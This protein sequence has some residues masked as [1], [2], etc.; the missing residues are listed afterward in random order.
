FYD[1]YKKAA[2]LT[3][4]DTKA[5][6]EVGRFLFT[7]WPELSEE[8]KLYTLGLL[9]NLRTNREN[10]QT[11]MQIWAINGGD[12]SVMEDILPEE[13]GVYR[14]FAQF[15]ANRKLSI[16]ERHKKLAQAE[17]M[18]FNSAKNSFVKGEREAQSRNVNQAISLF[19][20]SL[21]AIENLQFY[22]NLTGETLIDLLEVHEYKKSLY[23]N[24]IKYLVIQSGD[25]K[26]AEI[27]LR[28]YLD[29]ENNLTE[30]GDLD[31]FLKERN[32]LKA[33]PGTYFNDLLPYYIR[34]LIEYKLNRNRDIVEGGKNL[35]ESFSTAPE[36]LRKDLARICQLI[37]ESYQILDYLYDAEE[38]FNIAL[39]LDPTHLDTLKGM[40]QN[41]V[42]LNKP[43]MAAG[44]EN[45]IESM[46]TPEE[47]DFENLRL[48][49]GRDFKQT[50][51]LKAKKIAIILTLE[52][53][54]PDRAPLLAI[55]FN[56]QLIWENYLETSSLSLTVN[57]EEGTN[58]LSILPTI[59][60]MTL[61]K[62]VYTS[63]SE[64]IK[65]I[66]RERL[67]FYKSTETEQ[68]KI[69]PKKD[70]QLEGQQTEDL[71]A[72]TKELDLEQDKVPPN[73]TQTKIEP[74]QPTQEI[75]QSS[76]MSFVNGIEYT[77][78]QDNLEI[79]ILI[80]HYLTT[81]T[82]EL[83]N[84]DRIILDISG[85]ADIKSGR[86]FEIGEFPVQEV[87]LGMFKSD[88]ARVVFSVDRNSLRY[89]VEKTAR[90][91]KVIFFKDT[92]DINY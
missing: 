67:T 2:R 45:Q 77:A 47:I 8:D 92:L 82:F 22:Q 18:E 90:G 10:L 36:A 9:R 21:K 66:E 41:Y 78:S 42:K 5:Y 25:L 51:F 28:K 72:Q 14:T 54:S 91:I 61:K 89:S 17:F 31:N 58:I 15:L 43:E 87:R 16:E 4:F 59:R 19:N 75:E 1:E 49:R 11:I 79:E 56:D 85:I 30:I 63:D 38:F 35:K 44:V 27:Y 86:R 34:V 26:E 76:S 74:T 60:D 62:I 71:V 65:E 23:L 53:D 37:G 13:A 32:L 68:V 12:F 40:R 20:A 50:F 57:T 81:N 24:L 55:K 29:L 64:I 73:L 33:E 48:Q 46:L 3:T 52:N 7:H 69:P 39:N 70:E 88:T 6:F 83:S 80:D 84:P